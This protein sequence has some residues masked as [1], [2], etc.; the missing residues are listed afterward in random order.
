MSRHNFKFVCWPVLGALPTDCSN[1]L[2]LVCTRTARR[3]MPQAS[4]SRKRS[5]S[6]A[7]RA[8]SSNGAF[9]RRTEGGAVESIEVRV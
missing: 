1:C 9:R 4:P 8:K 5:L 2:L 3:A 6:R 7:E